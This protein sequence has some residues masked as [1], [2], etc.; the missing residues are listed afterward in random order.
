MNA[1]PAELVT[2]LMSVFGTKAKWLRSAVTVAVRGIADITEASLVD[3]SD[4]ELGRSK[5]IL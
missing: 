1:A 2:D 4:V 5:T 3:R